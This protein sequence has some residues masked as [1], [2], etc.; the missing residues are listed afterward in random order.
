MP[1]Q[2]ESP[3]SSLQDENTDAKH[4]NSQASGKTELEPSTES[5]E[6]QNGKSIRWFSLAYDLGLEG[7]AQEI[8]VNSTLDQLAEQRIRLN[9]SP[10]IYKLV[11]AP[12]EEEIRQAISAKL[13][14]SLKLEFLTQDQLPNETPH[15][16]LQRRLKEQREAI[17]EEIKN[18]ELV[19]KLNRAFGAE[20]VETSVTRIDET[21]IPV[22]SEN[23]RRS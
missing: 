1:E 5:L 19:R 2:Q 16:C 13:G 3:D 8:A 20:L 22:S 10:L 6:D 11:T 14:V 18:D 4:E 12:I 15:L 21:S 23:N 7:L 17:I 9:V